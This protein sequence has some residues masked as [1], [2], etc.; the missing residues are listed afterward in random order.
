MS[1]IRYRIS[2]KG[3]NIALPSEIRKILKWR[4]NEVLFFRLKGNEIEVTKADGHTAKLLKSR[5]HIPVDIARASN[6][7]DG[8]IV[9]LVPEKD[10]KLIIKL[11]FKK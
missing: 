9:E 10:G 8:T 2:I 6:I 4:T 7:R 1:T 3:R 5:L 11:V